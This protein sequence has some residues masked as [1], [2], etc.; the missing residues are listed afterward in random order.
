MRC[1]TYFKMK[2]ILNIVKSVT[3]V[4]FE[5]YI[6]RFICKS[7]CNSSQLTPTL[8]YQ[9]IQAMSYY[10]QWRTSLQYSGCQETNNSHPQYAGYLILYESSWGTQGIYINRY[11]YQSCWNVFLRVKSWRRIATYRFASILLSSHL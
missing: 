8:N 3:L 9:S 5:S 10:W 4:F 2:H 1:P 11:T 6:P 7:M